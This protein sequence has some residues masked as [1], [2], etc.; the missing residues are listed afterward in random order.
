MYAQLMQR[1]RKP[2]G[3]LGTL[4]LVSAAILGVVG[5]VGA[6]A[7]ILSIV[8]DLNFWANDNASRFG[9]LIFFLVMVLGAVGFVIEDE[10]A[11]AGGALGVLGGAALV[12]I[13]FWTVLAIVVGLGVAAVAVL[14]ARELRQ[15][16]A[17]RTRPAH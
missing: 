15:P 8:A 14:R 16:T 2:G 11:W 5:L 4:S 17:P 13:L 7:M 6:V 9:S 1:L 10:H 12:M 3:R